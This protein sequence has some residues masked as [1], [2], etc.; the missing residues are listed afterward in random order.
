ME[1][2]TKLDLSQFT[3]TENYYR[4]NP[5]FAKDMVHTDGVQYFADNAGCYWF[6]DIIATEVFP[7]LKK[8]PFLSIKFWVNGGEASITV[9]DGDL[10]PL[11]VKGIEH[12]DCPDGD[13]QFFLTNNVLMLTSEY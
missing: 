5:F 12:T 11:F 3:G 2:T 10:K 13:Y 8:E 1:S 6:L 7:L 4:T 9:E